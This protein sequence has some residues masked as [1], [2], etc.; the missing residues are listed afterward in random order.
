M[1]TSPLLDYYL[2]F[3]RTFVGCAPERHVIY[4]EDSTMPLMSRHDDL[5]VSVTAA[6]RANYHKAEIWLL[7]VQPDRVAEEVLLWSLK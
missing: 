3:R 7:R 2:S 4:E 5:I 1:K 6:G